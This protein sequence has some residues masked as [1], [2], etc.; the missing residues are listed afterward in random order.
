MSGEP[1]GE[2]SRSSDGKRHSREELSPHDSGQ[3]PRKPVAAPP[4]PAGGYYPQGYP[5]PVWQQYPYDPRS[6][7]QRPGEAPYGGCGGGPYYGTGYTP[8]GTPYNMQ[9]Y[10]YNQRFGPTRPTMSDEPMEERPPQY[11]AGNIPDERPDVGERSPVDAEDAERQKEQFAF[12]DASIRAA[13][14]RKVFAIVFVMCLV[15]TVM[16]IPAVVVPEVRA[17]MA[18]NVVVYFIA[19]I[20]FIGTMCAIV[21][22]AQVAR[23]FPLN[24]VMLTIFTLAAG[25]V[26]MVV[27]AAV[28][29]HTVLMALITTTLCCLAI[30]LF[31]TQ[32]SIDITSYMFLIFAATAALFMFG[33]VLSIMSFFIR[34]KFMHIVYS[35]LACVLF[36]VYLAFDTQM[37]VGGRKYELSPEE[38]IYAALMLFLDI[39]NIFITILSLFQQAND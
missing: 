39:Y 20:V 10:P 32:T 33:I 28:P 14:V 2:G 13:F 30:I 19:M 36:M 35:A 5:Y 27:C 16:V 29:P 15:V 4:Y 3:G 22:C 12:D 37:I 6:A 38:Y 1:V 24:L 7:P 34:M 8:Y 21:C 11:R 9:A 23:R 31:A 25:V 17:A 26:L 18:G